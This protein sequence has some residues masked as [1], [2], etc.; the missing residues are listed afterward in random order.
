MAKLL[1][2]VQFRQR[3]HGPH[4]LKADGDNA[5][6][7]GDDGLAVHHPFHLSLDRSVKVGGLP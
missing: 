4:R 1:S 5:V 6:F 7:V 2:Y 3:V